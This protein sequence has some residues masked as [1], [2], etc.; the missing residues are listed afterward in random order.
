MAVTKSNSNNSNS[1]RLRMSL[2]TTST[3]ATTNERT[4]GAINFK[5]KYNGKVVISLLISLLLSC[6]QISM[7][8]CLNS[9]S[10][11]LVDWS[12]SIDLDENYRV[13]WSIVDQEI[14]FEIQVRATG[15]VG[16]GFSPDGT[17]YAADM[18]IG[19]ID[20]GQ[21]YFQDRHIKKHGDGEPVVD[22][23][24]D[25]I[26][27]AG[28]GNTTHTV[29]RF[30]RKLD[31]CDSSHDIPITNN[32]MKILFMYHNLKPQRGSITPGSLPSPSEAFKH[33]IPV[34]LT[35]RSINSSTI[36]NQKH[37]EFMDLKN[38]DAQLPYLDETV[39]WC[40]MFKLSQFSKK[41][42]I[43]RYEPVFDSPSSKMYLNHI[44][45]YEC[46]GSSPEMEIMSREYGKMC[47]QPSVARPFGCNNIVATWV[48]GSDGFAFPEAAGYPLDSNHA[49]FY[50]MVTQY[51]N[52]MS[53]FS[54]L[55]NDGMVDNSGL[56]IYYTPKLRQHD[57][58]VLSIGMQP[59][60]RHIIP[61]GQDSV[62]SE[63]HCVEECTK[64]AFPKQG[65]NIFATMMRTHLIGKQ[66]K[67]RHI[68]GREELLPIAS[69]ANTDSRYQE[70]RLLENP[71]KSYPGDRLIAE[72]IYDT[73]RRS[74]LTLGGVSTREET[75]LVFTMYYPRQKE[76]STCHSLPSLPTVLHSLGIE[77]LAVGSNPVQI[78]LPQKLA[79]MSL[80]T[81]LTTYDW[82][83]NFEMFQRVTRMGSFKPMC[84]NAKGAELPGTRELESFSPNISKT[85]RLPPT[86]SFKYYGSNNKI[87]SMYNNRNRY[88]TEPESN[89]D[90]TSFMNEESDILA[91]EDEGNDIIQIAA[92]S[93]TSRSFDATL[94]N[95]CVR[96]TFNNSNLVLAMIVSIF[97]YY[98][99]TRRR[100][101]C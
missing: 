56:R 62:V 43:V 65:I 48:R 99:V 72:C 11:S 86:C 71:I 6:Y 24:Q 40:K 26:L 81:R 45:L 8:S 97:Y 96:L 12:H 42:H 63:G 92:R 74:T 21:P 68:R 19:W 73:T 25:Y 49:R 70:F 9:G 89:L 20:G 57:A 14:T 35:Q 13:Y 93:K 34:F 67:L 23:S 100:I 54:A 18:V 15:Y 44:L 46:H 58:G 90:A 51:A 36:R 76:L 16:F 83:T 69:D 41:N 101:L 37:L 91:A 85:W 30:K 75:C 61:P 22:P 1:C 31:T 17:I 4:R 94:T 66:V 27:L 29:F 33:V 2:A 50:L 52:L 95:N 80:E 55:H 60:W 88:V 84:M 98:I 3:L 82:D 79:G 47:P 32:T 78:A 39:H 7:V 53:D 28:Y 5:Y 87:H 59:N 64:R 77:E 38:E 10:S